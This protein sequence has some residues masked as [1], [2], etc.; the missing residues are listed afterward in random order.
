MQHAGRKVEPLFGQED[1]HTNDAFTMQRVLIVGEP[2][3]MICTVSEKRGA[4]AARDQ[5]EAELT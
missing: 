1:S 3:F 4:A 5:L 2:L